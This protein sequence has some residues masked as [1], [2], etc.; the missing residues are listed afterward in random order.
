MSES[1]ADL[2]IPAEAFLWRRV[3]PKQLKRNPDGS[4]RASSASFKDSRGE[5]SV[6]IA[7]LTTL[8]EILRRRPEMSVAQVTAGKVRSLGYVVIA[9]PTADDPS[10]AVITPPPQRGRG[11][12][13][14]DATELASAS[15]LIFTGFVPAGL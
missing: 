1:H 8:E 13:D 4:L 12:V 2:Q 5:L 9:A 3:H 15:T 11:Q 7:S 6:H 14:R 10:H